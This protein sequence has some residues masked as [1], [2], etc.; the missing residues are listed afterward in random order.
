MSI[1]TGSGGSGFA[2]S[3][4]SQ[5]QLKYHRP[6]WFEGF[7]CCLSSVWPLP[8]PGRSRQAGGPLAGL[9]IDASGAPVA[10]ATVTIEIAGKPARTV[11]TGVDGRFRI[12][13]ATAGEGTLRVRASGFA[14][15]VTLVDYG[16]RGAARRLA[17]ASADRIGHGHRVARRHRRRHGGELD[18]RVVGRTP[19]VG[20]RRD[21]RCAAQHAG[22]QPVPPL[23]VAGREP[24][25]AGRHAARCVRVG[26]QPDA[27]RGRRLGAQRSVR[28]L[29]VLEPHSARR[30][31]S[32]RGRARGDRRSVRGGRAR[33]RH[34]GADARRRA[35]AAARA[36][37]RRV[38]RHLPCLRLRRPP[39]RQ[40]GPFSWREGQNTDGVYIVADEVRGAVDVPAYSDYG[41]GF[42][43]VG[44]G[45]GT[46]RATLRANFASESRGNGTPLQVNDTEW[47]QFAGRCERFPGGRFLDCA[48]D[49]RHARTTSRRS[50]PSRP[51]ASRNG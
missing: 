2:G 40:L 46:W 25:D 19:D 44:Y 27:R 36:L 28:Q 45:S 6:Q 30:D 13:E 31:R 34:T 21:R 29:G 4:F 11:E 50:R 10:G 49:R 43:A 15:S 12:D 5:V 37:R 22:V 18:D 1:Q 8:R 32:H 20:R 3:G 17:A 7:C 35:A 39:L 26:S 24:D 51:I 14:E 9:V 33:R 41:S 42:A 38:A 48:S 47:R 23:V 16:C